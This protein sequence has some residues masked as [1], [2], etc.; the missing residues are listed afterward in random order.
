MRQLIALTAFVLALAIAPAASA[1]HS[2]GAKA[3]RDFITGAGTPGAGC[4]IV[5]IFCLPQG[6]HFS[7]NAIGDPLGG[8][9]VGHYREKGSPVIPQMTA[10]VA[11]VSVTGNSGVMAARVPEERGPNS[12]I[13]RW[14]TD[15]GHDAPDLVSPPFLITLGAGGGGAVV[16]PPD[17]PNTCVA[18][19]NPLPFTV[20]PL[21]RGNIVVH[22]G[23]L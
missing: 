2:Q 16:I 6:G 20:L 23:A 1:S 12:F 21:I 10:D 9:A 5:P 4:V 19:I 17:F 22:D 7:V 18:A 3:P 8:P 11:C 13:I 14:F 15:G